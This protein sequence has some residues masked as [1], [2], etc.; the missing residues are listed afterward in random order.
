MKTVLAIRLSSLGDV[1]MTLPVLRTVL[2]SNPALQIVWLTRA[3]YIPYFTGIDRLL[4]VPF[5]GEGR[6]RGLMGCLRAYQ[7]L[8]VYHIS[9]VIDLHGVIRTAVISTLFFVSFK[10]VTR[11]RKYRRLRRKILRGDHSV[12]IPHT[13]QRYSETF[14]KAGF[15]ILHSRKPELV[16]AA[17]RNGPVTHIGIAPLAKHPTKV[18]NLDNMKELITLLTND[19]DQVVHLFGSAGER[20]V[21]DQFLMDRTINEAGLYPPLE[22]LE[23]IRSMD[24]FISMDSAN[25]HLAALAGVPSLTIWG[26]TDPAM[27]FYPLNQPAGYAI[28]ADSSLVDCRPCSVFGEKPCRRKTD[29]MRCM[30]VI[31]PG[32]VKRSVE[33]LLAGSG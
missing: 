25:M 20:E 9:R 6:H 5:D 29:Q 33:D 31:L 22:E 13:T 15:P 14:G 24:L 11:I 12:S 23:L 1:L 3:A 21:L 28:K 18:W 26:S 27:G 19:N 10:P 16:V 4:P 8:K 30:N 32:Q 7:D 17:S 2:D